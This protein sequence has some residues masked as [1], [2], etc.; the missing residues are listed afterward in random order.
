[1]CGIIGSIGLSRYHTLA[2][3]R[4]GMSNIASR[5]R[6]SVGMHAGVSLRWV[7]SWEQNRD[8]AL[9]WAAKM[10][11]PRR[12]ML[13]HTRAATSGKVTLLNAHPISRSGAAMVHN[14][15]VTTEEKLPKRITETDTEYALLLLLKYGVSSKWSKALH[16]SG[17]FLVSM[18]ETLMAY[19][20]GSPS[21]PLWAARV[22]SKGDYG[23][24]FASTVQA[25]GRFYE[26]LDGKVS[27]ELRPIKAGVS[28]LF[29]KAKTGT[30]RAEVPCEWGGISSWRSPYLYEEWESYSD[31]AESK[32]S[33]GRVRVYKY[34]R[35]GDES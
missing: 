12:I 3:F 11:L 31:W 6:D 22:K 13:G 34:K 8:E 4:V 7:G 21:T 27:I 2:W 15:I 29:A 26:Y 9:H 1:M 30:V 17:A 5:G 10:V 14:G 35:R 16:G 20:S 24:I 25:F 32:R 28:Y 33:Q 18:G 23:Y 19:R